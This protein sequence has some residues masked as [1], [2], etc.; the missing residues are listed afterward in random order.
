MI[1]DE[2]V[3]NYRIIFIFIKL[4]DKYNFYTIIEHNYEDFKS[5]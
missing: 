2:L 5:K 1:A 4:K 3:I